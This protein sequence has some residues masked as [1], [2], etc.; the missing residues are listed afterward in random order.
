MRR[1][2]GR[3]RG[4]RVKVFDVGD[5]CGRRVHR[6]SRGVPGQTMRLAAT[7]FPLKHLNNES[8]AA[9]RMRLTIQ[10]E[11]TACWKATAV[12]NFWLVN[13]CQ[14]ATNATAAT[15]VL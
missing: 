7:K 13:S 15:M 14:A 4:L 3:C 11:P 10:R 5:G 6:S 12:M 8:N 9:A 2:S 1:W